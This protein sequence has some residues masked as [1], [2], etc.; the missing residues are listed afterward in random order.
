MST[1]SLLPRRYEQYQFTKYDKPVSPSEFWSKK[2]V[3]K[4]ADNMSFLVGGRERLLQIPLWKMNQ[5]INKGV[6]L[7]DVLKDPIVILVDD[8]KNIKQIG[9]AYRRTVT[10][11]PCCLFSRC[12]LPIELVDPQYYLFKPATT[13][14]L[15]H[16]P[17]LM[18][19]YI[20]IN[21]KCLVAVDG[22]LLRGET[23]NMPSPYRWYNSMEV[24]L[25]AAR[26]KA[27]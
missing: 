15:Y 11:E 21:R 24:S 7:W 22:D 16:Q 27:I 25:R 1:V 9:V 6:I 8:F 4:L 2:G 5:F 13:Y 18:K 14:D 23:R 3:E 12:L 17:N 10:S 20:K 26:E 19:N